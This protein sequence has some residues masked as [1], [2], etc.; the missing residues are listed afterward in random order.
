MQATSKHLLI[1]LAA[2]ITTSVSWGALITIEVT[3]GVRYRHSYYLLKLTPQMAFWIEDSVGQF[4]ATIYVTRFSSPWFGKRE[5]KRPATLPVWRNRGM[6]ACSPLSPDF[7]QSIEAITA[8]TPKAAF[9]RVLKADQPLRPGA[10]WIFAEVNTS[11]DF[12]ETFRRDLPKD[13]P[14][15]NNQNG[16]PSVIWRGALVVGGSSSSVMLQ[17]Y[18]HGAVLGE[19]GAIAREMTG[20]TTALH[21]LDAVRCAYSP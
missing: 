4:V 19:S 2:L 9:S 16:Q 15:Y 5:I 21:I 1:I 6:A 17:P 12:N 11:F 3:P 8:A 7:C 13:S 10:Y 14:Y 18:G 20:I